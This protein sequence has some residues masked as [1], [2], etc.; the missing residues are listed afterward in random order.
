MQDLGVTSLRRL[1]PPLSHGFLLFSLLLPVAAAHGQLLAPGESRKVNEPFEAAT[2]RPLDGHERFARWLHEDGGSPSI[3]L[4]VMML[5]SISEAA[6]T[7][8]EWGR[9]IEG[10]ARREGS[11]YGQYTIGTSIHEG[12]A[13]L[14]G[15]DPRYFPCGCSGLWRR[16]AHAI[17]MT[18]LT[19]NRNGHEVP[20]MAQLA[21]AYGGPMVAKLWY[22]AHYSPLVQGVQFGNIEVGIIGTIHMVQEFSPELREFFH[23]KERAM[24]ARADAPNQTAAPKK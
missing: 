6:G 15:T 22:P 14:T 21:G 24:V 11:E 17:K 13:A 12:M 8:P 3:H 10:Y 5:A 18:F 9:G 7:P 20:D 19:Y 23:V 16:S 1:L 4:N 2:Y